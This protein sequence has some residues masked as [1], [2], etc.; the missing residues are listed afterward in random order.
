[1]IDVVVGSHVRVNLI[2]LSIELRSRVQWLRHF[3]LLSPLGRC[4]RLDL[5]SFLAAAGGCGAGCS[6]LRRTRRTGG[7]RLLTTCRRRRARSPTVRLRRVLRP[8]S[9]V[10]A[11]VVELHV[12]ELVQLVHVLQVVVVVL[13]VQAGQVSEL[14]LVQVGR[15]RVT[16]S[17]PKQVLRP[18]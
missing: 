10:Q 14:L 15:L 9:V 17:S 18:I 13:V 2:E 5:L 6:P 3:A 4:R 11:V 8:V 16:A 12:V 7:S 1:M